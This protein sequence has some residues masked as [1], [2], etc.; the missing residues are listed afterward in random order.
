MAPDRVKSYNL[1]NGLQLWRILKTKNQWLL[2]N[3][4]TKQD[5]FIAL[6]WQSRFQ[7]Q[8]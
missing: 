7:N 3:K 2:K 6:N 5:V 8:I 4:W 1:L